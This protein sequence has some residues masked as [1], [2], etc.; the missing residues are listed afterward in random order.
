MGIKTI[1]KQLEKQLEKLE[2]EIEHRDG[3]YYDRSEVWQE[4]YNGIEYYGKI[5]DLE[6][7]LDH[8]VGAIESLN[9]FLGESS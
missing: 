8:L 7:A 2:S 6:I 1:K 5:Q 9:D 4:S 3:I